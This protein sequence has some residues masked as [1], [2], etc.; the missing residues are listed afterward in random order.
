MFILDK[1]SDL[2]NSSTVQDSL[3][4]VTIEKLLKVVTL[5]KAAM[6]TLYK[7]I[8]PALYKFIRKLVSSSR[9]LPITLLC[10]LVYLERLQN[11]LP[12][13]ARATLD[14]YQRIYCASLILATKYLHDTSIKN[15]YWAYFTETYDLAS[16]NMMEQQMLSLLS[17]DLSLNAD[18]VV[19][20]IGE[21]PKVLNSITEAILLHTH[22]NRFI[23]E[24]IAWPWP[25]H[26]NPSLSV[27][28]K[29]LTGNCN[30]KLMEEEAEQNDI[31]TPISW[32]SSHQMVPFSPDF[33]EIQ[34]LLFGHSA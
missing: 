5:Q 24:S 19:E 25:A 21:S 31:L 8:V 11:V 28:D 22:H 9:T 34:E 29:F 13:N 18:R 23:H 7:E 12:V 2:P 4:D 10:V 20:M 32:Q 26:Q 16:V 15:K 17:F 30:S 6:S 1:L 33:P 14:T 3:V 27:N